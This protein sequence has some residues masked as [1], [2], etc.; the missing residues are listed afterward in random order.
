MR[1][2]DVSVGYTNSHIEKHPQVVSL[3]KHMDYLS[4]ILDQLARESKLA[5]KKRFQEA[6][7]CDQCGGRGWTVKWDTMDS[8]SGCYAEYGPCPAKGCTLETRAR[9]GL[10][11]SYFTKYDRLNSVRLPVIVNPL[12]SDTSVAC[13]NVSVKLHE[14][15]VSLN[16]C[17]KGRVVRVAGGRRVAVGTVGTVF[18]VGQGKPPYDGLRL[19][20]QTGPAREDVVWVDAKHCV[21]VPSPS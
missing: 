19:G 6:G 11:A 9:S 21:A 2:T 16:P 12:S 15:V 3:R 14:T 8:M 20:V 17:V 18:W 7:G 4:G 1:S 10:D 13:M 5:E